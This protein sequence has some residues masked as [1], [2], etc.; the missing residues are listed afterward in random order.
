MLLSLDVYGCDT[1]ATFRGCKFLAHNPVRGAIV[2]RPFYGA[3]MTFFGNATAVQPRPLVGRNAV[4]APL[5][6]AVAAAASRCGTG[7]RAGAIPGSLL[8]YAPSPGRR[9]TAG[10]RADAGPKARAKSLCMFGV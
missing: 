7:M 5:V 2:F 1:C 10:S 4:G 6:L 9:G 8:V 3:R